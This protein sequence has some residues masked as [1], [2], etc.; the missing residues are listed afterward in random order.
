MKLHL[1][2]ATLVLSACTQ[3]LTDQTYTG[4]KY[5]APA[6]APEVVTRPECGDTTLFGGCEDRPAPATPAP[7][8]KPEKPKPEKPKP[9][10][11]A[12]L[13]AQTDTRKA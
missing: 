2:A 11:C 6:P 3:T 4:G 7:P 9:D 13:P 10:P 8:P 12:C 1:I 5:A